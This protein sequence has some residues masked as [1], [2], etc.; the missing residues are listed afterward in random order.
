[1]RTCV[2][3]GAVA[4]LRNAR[5]TLVKDLF[6]SSETG[7]FGTF[8]QRCNSAA[9]YESAHWVIATVGRKLETTF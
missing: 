8:S 5:A 3:N 9:M 6:E 7:G 4:A 2:N 1:M